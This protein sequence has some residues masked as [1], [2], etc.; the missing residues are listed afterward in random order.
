MKRSSPLE[1]KTPLRSSSLAPRV[2][3]LEAR[4]ARLP[5]MSAKRR[6]AAPERRAVVEQVLARDGRR[7]RAPHAEMVGL[8]GCY[9]PLDCHEVIPR[10]AWAAGY[11][12][13]DNC[14]TLARSCHEWVGANVDAAHDLGLHGFSWERLDLTPDHRTKETL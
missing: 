8:D 2:V 14:L 7:C 12:V 9:G 1:R 11:L 3:A 5:Q 13:A 10:S 6:D 4:A